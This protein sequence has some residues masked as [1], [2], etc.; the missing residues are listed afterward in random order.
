MGITY[1]FW[2]RLTIAV[3]GAVLKAISAP[4]RQALVDAINQLYQKAKQTDNPYDDYFIE[5]LARLLGIELKPYHHEAGA[6][7]DTICGNTGM[8][9]SSRKTSHPSRDGDQK[10]MPT[11]PRP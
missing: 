7:C 4:L 1:A 5:L 8:A 6:T 2:E 3:L 10:D 9:Y 11:T